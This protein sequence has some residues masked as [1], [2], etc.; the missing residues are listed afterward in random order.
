MR[1]TQTIER[2]KSMT[3]DTSNQRLDFNGRPKT[4]ALAFA[5]KHIKKLN[6]VQ[7]KKARRCYS[8]KYTKSP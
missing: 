4:Y 5:V 8:A 6:V 3:D 7:Y 1:Y 2:Q